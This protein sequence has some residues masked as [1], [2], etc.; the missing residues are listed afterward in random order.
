[1]D[2]TTVIFAAF[3]LAGAFALGSCGGTKIIAH[4]GC[5][6]A[7]GAH[8]NTL[9]ALRGAQELGVWG[10][11][12]DVW[13]TSDNVP[14]VHHDAK[15]RDGDAI[16]F[17]PAAKILATVLPGG[18]RIPSLEQY[19]AAGAKGRTRLVLE[20]K[21]HSTPERDSAAAGIVMRMVRSMVPRGGIDYI[22]FSR[23][24]C[25]SL[26]LADPRARVYYLNGDLNPVQ[27][28]RAGYAG[29]DYNLSVMRAN[30]TWFEQ[31]RR[32]G[33]KV[34]VWTVNGQADM[35]WVIDRGADFITTDRPDLALELTGR[36]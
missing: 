30:E 15:T 9:A 22:S 36:R 6:S 25:E 27:A 1:M 26:V 23:A 28:A 17:S 16:E 35:Q 24:V 13:I 12:F 31:A 4:R 20:I 21:K 3:A 8:E 34:N 18:E 2:R 7:G 10:S 32:E 5:H 29:I 33:L 19:L 14:V 11:E